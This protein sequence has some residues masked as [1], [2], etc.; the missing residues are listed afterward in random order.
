MNVD[1]LE[2]LPHFFS[3]LVSSLI[4]INVIFKKNL[5]YDLLGFGLEGLHYRK[6]QKIVKFTKKKLIGLFLIHTLRTSSVMENL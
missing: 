6:G 4:A 5:R 3:D 2:T 1:A